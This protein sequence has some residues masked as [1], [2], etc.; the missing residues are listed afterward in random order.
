VPTPVSARSTTSSAD[1][2]KLGV[3]ELIEFDPR[4]PEYILSIPHTGVFVPESFRD[5]FSLG[6]EAWSRSTA[7]AT[8]LRDG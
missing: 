1:R 7:T 4:S 2:Y 3:R 6:E 8:S 5:R